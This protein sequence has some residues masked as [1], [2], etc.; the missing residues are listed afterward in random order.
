MDKAKLEALKRSLK[1]VRKDLLAS[2]EK[3]ELRA[4]SQLMAG[5][6]WDAI[7]TV[8]SARIEQ[9]KAE[10]YRQILEMI[11]SVENA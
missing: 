4:T 5:L 6:Y 10:T 9:A 1:N 3:Y 7:A 8:T 2:K 11:E